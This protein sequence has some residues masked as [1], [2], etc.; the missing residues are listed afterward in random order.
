[1]EWNDITDLMEC[2]NCKSPLAGVIARL[3]AAHKIEWN[4]MEWLSRGSRPLKGPLDL[5]Q[6][7]R[8]SVLMP[9]VRPI[10]GP[11]PSTKIL[12]KSAKIDEF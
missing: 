7:S 5:L 4:E 3:Q 9:H 1:M 10:K 2:I 8:G 12:K 11:P 6:G